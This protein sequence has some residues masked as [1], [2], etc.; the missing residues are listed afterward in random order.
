MEVGQDE[1]AIVAGRKKVEGVGGESDT[2]NIT[3]VYGEG[4]EESLAADV[5]ESAASV[6][7]ARHEKTTRRIHTAGGNR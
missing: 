1:T 7:V 2:A 5:V 4:L 6:L 3:R